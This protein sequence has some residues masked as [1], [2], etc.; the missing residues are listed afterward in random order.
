[1]CRYIDHTKADYI[2][3]R[4]I[5]ICIQLFVIGVFYLLF[6]F[7]FVFNKLINSVLYPSLFLSFHVSQLQPKHVTVNNKLIK[8]KVVT[9]LVHILSVLLKPREMFH[10]N[11]KTNV[12]VTSFIHLFPS[13][14]VRQHSQPAPRHV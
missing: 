5:Y 1:M 11:T 12:G 8:I 9:V 7:Y 6:L 3:I 10:L 4:D 13:G 14:L 2:Y